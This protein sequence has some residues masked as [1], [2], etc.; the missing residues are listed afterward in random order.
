MRFSEKSFHKIE[1]TNEEGAISAV[2]V[3]V[4]VQDS[5]RNDFLDSFIYLQVA[6]ESVYTT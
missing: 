6:L 3:E 2:N 1:A 5:N 4:A